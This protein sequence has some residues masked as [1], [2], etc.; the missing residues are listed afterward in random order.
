MTVFDARPAVL[1]EAALIIEEAL[2]AM[3]A[4]IGAELRK[5]VEAMREEARA[6]I[7]D[8]KRTFDVP[9]DGL[10]HTLPGG[11]CASIFASAPVNVEIDLAA[12]GSGRARNLVHVPVTVEYELS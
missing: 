1:E 7:D 5:L 6:G 3:K 10:W 11:R 8:R 12:D 2:P 4:G 9:P